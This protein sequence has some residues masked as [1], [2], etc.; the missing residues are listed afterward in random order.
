[1]LELADKFD[2]LPVAHS[3]N[4]VLDCWAKSEVDGA[5]DGALELLRSMPDYGV[6][7]GK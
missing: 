1:M 3:F 6:E 5:A 2:V 4:I 7:P